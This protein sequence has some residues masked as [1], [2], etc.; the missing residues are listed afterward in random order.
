MKKTEERKSVLIRGCNIKDAEEAVRLL[1]ETDVD[2]YEM[3]SNEPESTFIHTL[4]A[5]SYR[6]MKEIKMF[7]AMNKK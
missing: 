4:S 2:F 6:G 3:F 5:Y 1:K 7:A